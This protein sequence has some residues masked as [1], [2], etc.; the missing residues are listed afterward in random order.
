MLA[1]VLAAVGRGG[2]APVEVARSAKRVGAR[3][4]AVSRLARFSYSKLRG[5]P[6]IE[7]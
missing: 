2:I 3:L 5:P 7:F 4:R 1:T 6:Q